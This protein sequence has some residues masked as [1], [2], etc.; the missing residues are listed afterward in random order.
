SNF[1]KQLCR[2]CRGRCC[3]GHPGVWSDPQRFFAIFAASRIP[4]A[5]ELSILLN[6]NRLELRNLDGVLI[7]APKTT[8]Q[9]CAAQQP[10]GCAFPP[11]TRPCQCLAL[12]P[13]LE[14][15]L[16]DQIHCTLPAEYGSGTARENWRSF[17][18][19]LKRLK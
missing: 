8:E 17:Q 13:N 3:Q 18:P 5:G 19:L 1:D 14:T 12:I 4:A 11:A 9:G 2:Q 15:L 6:K 7:P 10:E 16:D